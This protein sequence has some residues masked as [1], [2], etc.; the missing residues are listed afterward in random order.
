ME[1]GELRVLASTD[2]DRRDWPGTPDSTTVPRAA[3]SSGLDICD[4]TICS[5]VGYRCCGRDTSTRRR[6]RCPTTCSRDTCCSTF[7]PGCMW[8][9]MHWLVGIASVNRCSIGWPGSFLGIVGSAREARCPS[10]RY[11]AYGPGIDRRAIVGVDDVAGGAAARAIVAGMIVGAE[12]IQRRIEQPR[13]LQADEHRIGAVLGAQAAVLSRVRGLPGSSS[14]SGM[15][16]SAAR[17]GRRAR[18]FAACCPAAR[19]RSAA[20]DRDTARRPCVAISSSR[21]RRHGLQ[22]LRRAVHAVAFAEAGPFERHG[23]VVVEGRAP[24]HA[25]VR[26]HALATCSTSLAW[27]APQLMWATRKSPGLTKRMN[28]GDSWFSSV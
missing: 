13:L 6:F 7:V 8:Q 18:R 3:V 19:F 17:S 11:L 15:P 22:P 9:T 28:S 24:Q 27:H 12:E 26:H 16:T 10:G 4:W 2:S 21:R 1:I 5:S 23:A 25:A 14:V 20:A